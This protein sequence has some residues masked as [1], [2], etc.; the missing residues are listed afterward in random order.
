MNKWVL[1]IVALIIGILIYNI[2]I[3]ICKCSIVIEGKNIN[4]AVLTYYNSYPT[5]CRASDVPSNIPYY[6]N[7]KNI[8]K[9][10]YCKYTDKTECGDYSGCRWVGQVA[11]CPNS[12][13]PIDYLKN[14]YVVAFISKE[15]SKK[16]TKDDRIRYWNNNYKNKYINITIT[17][18]INNNTIEF[19]AIILD[20]CDDSDCGGCCTKNMGNKNGLIDI[21]YYSL[22]KLSNYISNK[23]PE[24]L[25]NNKNNKDFI[26]YYVNKCKDNC[27]NCKNNCTPNNEECKCGQGTTLPTIVGSDK[28][29]FIITWRITNK[30]GKCPIQSKP[31]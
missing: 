26:D 6:K 3:N 2:L 1:C 21:E 15:Q 31:S 13:I 17:N 24:F 19:K 20:T 28:S 7:I 16:K 22:V 11:G 14:N 18:K 9:N 25:A 27:C 23:H 8:V 10:E 12:Y 30:T 4:N 29:Q 5:C